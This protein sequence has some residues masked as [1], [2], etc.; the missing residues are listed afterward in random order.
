MI[1]YKAEPPYPQS[2]AS[3]RNIIFFC[4]NINYCIERPQ[5]VL[6]LANMFCAV[7]C[8]SSPA[9]PPR[10]QPSHIAWLLF[11]IFFFSAT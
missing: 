8:R 3:T 6:S 9:C 11:V 7:S 1:S 5:V 10:K 4:A 2:L